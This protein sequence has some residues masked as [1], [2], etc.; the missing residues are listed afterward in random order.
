[1]HA[2]IAFLHEQ[3]P[4]FDLGDAGDQLAGGGAFVGDQDL[5]V[6]E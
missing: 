6:A 4:P 2:G 3:M 5:E 1:V